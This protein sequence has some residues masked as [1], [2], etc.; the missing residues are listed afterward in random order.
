MSSVSRARAS[1]AGRGGRNAIFIACLGAESL[2]AFATSSSHIRGAVDP[3]CGSAFVSSARGQQPAGT[4]DADVGEPTLQKPSLLSFAIS[5]TQEAS[6]FGPREI[7]RTGTGIDATVISVPSRA[8]Q[9]CKRESIVG[10]GELPDELCLLAFLIRGGQPGN[11]EFIV[12][13]ELPQE[14]AAP[15]PH[16]L[17]SRKAGRKIKSL[18]E[19]AATTEVEDVGPRHPLLAEPLG[20]DCWVLAF[21]L[22][23][24]LV[25]RKSGSSLLNR[26]TT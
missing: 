8:V 3:R 16:C 11:K 15:V 14:A 18:P 9:V 10:R 21:E 2:P 22:T 20:A 24:T 7:H 19:V 6:A 26:I 5:A 1:A 23:T 4:E 25:S 12:I 13:S 17:S